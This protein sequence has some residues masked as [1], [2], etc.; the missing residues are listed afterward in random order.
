MTPLLKSILCVL[1]T[2]LSALLFTACGGDSSAPA[3]PS[4]GGAFAGTSISF[5]P[6]INFQAGDAL[7]YFNNEAGTPFPSADPAINGTYTYTPNASFT[8]GTLTLT[9]N[10]VASPLVLEI[11]NFRRSGANVSGFTARSG[12]QSYPVD[13][14]GTL[15]A[16][17]APASGG[18][19]GAGE[20]RADDI[21]SSVQGTYALTYFEATTGSGIADD[22]TATFTIAARTLAF[23]GKTLTNPVFLNGKNDEWI[24][25]DGNL[26][27]AVSKLSSGAFNEINVAGPGGTP[28]YGQYSDESEVGGGV[29]PVIPPPELPPFPLPT[30][31]PVPPPL[32]TP[33]P[34]PAPPSLE[35][36]A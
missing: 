24:F 5:N 28:F 25:K 31:T 2:A 13:V 7:T 30:P 18:S 20:T 35:F 11:S 9:L 12:G 4:S 8:A 14:T 36:Q 3:G 27:Y 1:F 6:T 34:T 33:T 22:S 29:V 21:P 23:G 16:Y 26:W 10:G 32:P 17:Q 19:T 15:V